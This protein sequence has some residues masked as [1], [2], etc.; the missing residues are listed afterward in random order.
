VRPVSANDERLS[1]CGGAKHSPQLVCEHR[2]DLVGRRLLEERVEDDD[3][4]RHG[5]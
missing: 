5:A 1:V 3:V 2:L 4:L